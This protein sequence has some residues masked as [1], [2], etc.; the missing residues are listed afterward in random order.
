MG[1]GFSLLNLQLRKELD[2]FVLLVNCFNLPG[3]RMTMLI[4]LLFGRISRG[5]TLGWSMRLS[6]GANIMKLADGLFLESCR[7]IATKYP[8]IKYNEMIV[9]DTCMQ[10]VSKPE[11][12][13]VMV[14]P[15]LYGNLVA[16]TAGGIAGETG[17]G[18]DVGCYI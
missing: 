11:Q 3:L 1:G 14:T 13:G 8:G 5:S 18:L 2:L 12:F 7:E 6:L 16:N 10:L 15:N 4:L 9:D 17:G